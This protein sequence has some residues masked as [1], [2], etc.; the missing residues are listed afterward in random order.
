MLPVFCIIS[1][2]AE[3]SPARKP[4]RIGNL[5]FSTHLLE[6]APSFY[7]E[8]SFLH[9]FLTSAYGHPLQIA[10]TKD[11]RKIARILEI[12]KEAPP[13]PES[14]PSA[15]FPYPRAHRRSAKPLRVSHLLDNPPYR[16]L[17][18]RPSSG[19]HI[20]QRADRV[21][22]D[23]HPVPC[24]QR[25]VVGRHNPGPRHQE[26]AVRKAVIAEQIFD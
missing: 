11:V 4:R 6:A 10:Q 2:P 14:G 3:T 9:F 18:T 26:D 20:F 1:L 13:L 12:S 19:H 21:D 7:A 22:G 15:L 17:Q 23:A 25:E 16:S 5:A 8:S 24:L